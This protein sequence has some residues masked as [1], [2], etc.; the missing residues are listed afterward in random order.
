MDDI[1]KLIDNG[2]NVVINTLDNRKIEIG[3]YHEYEISFKGVIND[4]YLNYNS[5]LSIHNTLI[6]ACLNLEHSIFCV[7][8]GF[9]ENSMESLRKV[10]ELVVFGIYF[11]KDQTAYSNWLSGK[12]EFMFSNK[13]NNIYDYQEILR[14][15]S[16]DFVNHL[17]RDVN[18]LFK[19]LS[20]YTHSNPTKW[21]QSSRYTYHL[22]FISDSFDN[23]F[24][25]FKMIMEYSV[26][27][28][29]LYLPESLN[30]ASSRIINESNLNIILSSLF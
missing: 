23:W 7:T 14:W 16:Y 12:S 27:L 22:E 29:V 5:K 19:K 6:E 1:E 30:E 20:E 4:I 24:D 10:I 2:L 21:Q 9:Y 15:T 17:K 18:K 8:N 26:T 28:L 13:L 11:D 3:I 25:S